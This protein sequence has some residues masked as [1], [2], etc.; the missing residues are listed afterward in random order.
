MNV[1]SAVVCILICTLPVWAQSGCLKGDCRN[2]KGQFKSSDG[3]VYVGDFT[4]GMLDGVGKLTYPD[5][6]VYQG[7]F[8]DGKFTGRVS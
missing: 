3:R 2:G 1:Y 8:E 4:A 5:G 6:T 7:G